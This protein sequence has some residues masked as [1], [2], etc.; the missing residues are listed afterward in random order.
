M[1]RFRAY[2]VFSICFLLISVIAARGEPPVPEVAKDRYGDPLPEGAVA[3]LGTLR[4]WHG[5][6]I[7]SVAFSPDSKSVVSGHGGIYLWDVATGK[8][9]CEFAGHESSVRSVEFTADGKT[10]VAANWATDA[11]YFW[12]VEARRLMRH[13]G[14]LP[15]GREIRDVSPANDIRHVTVSPDGKI[16]ATTQGGLKLWDVETAE[17][18]GELKAE[19]ERLHFVCATFSPDGKSLAAGDNDGNIRLWDLATKKVVAIL[20][21]HKETVL[22]LA[23]SPDGKT[24]ASGWED[25]H[26]C[27]WD[28]S[29]GKLIRPIEG[30]KDAIRSLAFTPDS[31]SLIAASYAR[32]SLWDASRGTEIRRYTGQGSGFDSVALSPDGKLLAAAGQGG[33]VRLWE[34]AT[35][36]PAVPFEGHSGSIDA[37]TFSPDGKEIVSGSMHE[38]ILWDLKARKLSRRLG[39]EGTGSH[40]LVYSQGGRKLVSSDYTSIRVW[41]PGTG[42]E[43]TRL[44]AGSEYVQRAIPLADGKIIASRHSSGVCRS[45][46]AVSGKLLRDFGEPLGEY[47]RSRS[48]FELSPDESLVA[49]GGTNAPTELRGL[50]DRRLI[51]RLPDGADSGFSAAFSPDG[52][53]IAV[54]SQDVCLFEVATGKEIRR[55]K[56]HKPWVNALAFSP[57][58]R[59][60]ASAGDDGDICLW[61]VATGKER[62][63]FRGHQ[64]RYDRI[65]C[66]AF[67]PGGELLASGG[68][69]TTMLLWDVAGDTMNGGLSLSEKEL[70]TTWADLID[71]DAS[72]AYA[73]MCRFMKSPA[74]S[75]PF[76]KEHLLA[77][78]QAD[79]KKIDRL[80]SD[81][82]SDEFEVRD[83]SSRELS[84]FGESAGPALNALLKAKPSAE[85]RRRAEE[86]LAKFQGAELS[87]ERLRELRAVEMLEHIGTADALGILKS[88]SD[89]A[90][91]A[92]LTREA[93][94]SLDRLAG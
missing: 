65:K 28:P 31:K 82:D 89:G 75:V 69:D 17:S 32:I 8:K 20:N 21:G 18:R 6:S 12:D 94:T 52:T 80:I 26:V 15:R 67:S 48:I 29:T 66:L 57:D 71:H 41:E 76:L 5:E 34:V 61:E 1:N 90:P 14:K 2:L 49:M 84:K 54:A 22:C 3:R 81:L 33:V 85:T 24:F 37:L 9:R 68:K 10:L 91:E 4:F 62:R 92:R 46:D 64:G 72:R 55:M 88:L 51:R 53:L 74:G 11:V 36:K 7:N 50:K 45:W 73:G 30:Y 42:K 79:P 19:R 56:K 44:P 16:L 70:A 27:L 35:G 58:G 63:C 47:Q 83:R 86:L 40:S 13:V 87:P 77:V 23:Y 59:S 38:T 60:I 39:E 43:L 78:P 25:G 93:K